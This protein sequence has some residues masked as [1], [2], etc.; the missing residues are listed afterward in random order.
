MGKHFELILAML[1]TFLI[2]KITDDAITGAIN[3]VKIACQQTCIS[4]AEEH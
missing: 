2:D 1:L 4:L 3:F